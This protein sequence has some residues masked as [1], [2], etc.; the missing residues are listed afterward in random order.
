MEGR[1]EERRVEG[2]AGRVVGGVV[3]LILCFV[4]VFFG[5]VFLVFG[6]FLGL[7][8]GIMVLGVFWVSGPVWKVAFCLVSA[9]CTVVHFLHF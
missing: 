8:F 4:F 1:K 6:C 3:V 9:L 2:R 7:F 5:G